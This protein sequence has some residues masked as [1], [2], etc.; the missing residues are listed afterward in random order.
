[1]DLHAAA[2]ASNVRRDCREPPNNLPAERVLFAFAKPPGEDYL[3]R[4]INP[5]MA[6]SGRRFAAVE[7]AVKAITPCCRANL[8]QMTGDIHRLDDHIMTMIFL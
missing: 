8:E 2:G 3:F 5:G 1:M 7:A 6:A 4:L